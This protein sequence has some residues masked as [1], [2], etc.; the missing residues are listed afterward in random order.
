M[1]VRQLR[2]YADDNGID[3]G[4]ATRKADILAILSE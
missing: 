4:S 2:D 1:T 3:L